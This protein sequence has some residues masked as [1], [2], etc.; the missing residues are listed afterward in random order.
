MD[1][2]HGRTLLEG[3]QAQNRRGYKQVGGYFDRVLAD[4]SFDAEIT[5]LETALSWLS[6]SL[7]F[8]NKHDVY[9]LIDNK[10]TFRPSST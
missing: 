9:F 2:L 5:A 8:I 6:I 4:S 1:L 10:G 7:G 3:K